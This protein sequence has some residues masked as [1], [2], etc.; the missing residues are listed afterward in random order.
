MNVSADWLLSLSDRSENATDIVANSLS[1]TR[2]P[3]ALVDEQIYQWHRDAAG[4]KIRYAPATLP[5]MFKTDAMLE[6]EYAQ[7]LGRTI[8]Q[9]IGT[10]KDR[11]NWLDAAINIRL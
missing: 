6:W 1:L 7:H 11:L 9:A 3:R 10:S 8:Q 2:A 4:Y 5:D